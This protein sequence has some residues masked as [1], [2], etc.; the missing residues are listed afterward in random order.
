MFNHK[1]QINGLIKLENDYLKR[2]CFKNCL[3]F[4]NVFIW[5]SPHLLVFS[6]SFS[7]SAPMVKLRSSLRRAAPAFLICCSQC[8]KS[9][10]PVALLNEL[11]PVEILLAFVGSCSVS[12]STYTKLGYVV[13]Q[14]LCN[15]HSYNP[16]VSWSKINQ[17][18]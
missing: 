14:G 16:A 2:S 10:C 11:I 18:L 1:S 8:L 4:Q 3:M 12:V 15:F 9:Q 6:T 5:S 17:T 7:S 13:S